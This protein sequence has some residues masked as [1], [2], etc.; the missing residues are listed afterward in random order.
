MMIERMIA[1]GQELLERVQIMTDRFLQGTYD[2]HRCFLPKRCGGLQSLF[3]R[4]LFAGIRLDERQ[5]QVIRDLPPDA[6]VVYAHKYKSYFDFLFYHTRYCQLGLPVPEVGF[7][8]FFLILQPISRFFRIIVAQT[9]YLFRNLSFRSPYLTG[10]IER[11]LQSGHHGFL[12]LVQRGGFYRR[13]VKDKPDPLRYL[14]D[15]QA[16]TPKPVYIVP[17]L[18][19]FTKSP[20]RSIPSLPDVLFG[21]KEN[22]G[23]LRRFF[24]MMQRRSSVFVEISEPLNLRAFL[25]QPGCQG[26]SRGK[27][28]TLLRRRLLDQLNRHRQSVTGPVLKSVEEL[29]E[30]ILTTDRL[31]EYMK[32]HAESKETPLYKIN[33]EAD[34]CI[35]EI[36]ARFNINVIRILAS[37][38][39]LIINLMF[40]G[41]S[42]DSDDIARLKK[43]A[44]KG[45][46]VLVPCHKSHIDYLILSYIL[47]VN[48]MPPPHIAA[49]KNLSF[50][51]MGPIFR[52]C[53]AFFIRRTFKGAVLYS[54][55]FSE[56][57]FKL[58]QEGFNVEFFIEGGRSR[59]GKLLKPKLGL[60]SIII[61]A[62]RQG[63]CED[64]VFVP[65][66]IG[67]DRVPEEGAY[68]HE[69]EGGQK[70]PESL[71]EMIK[72][73]KVLK[74]RYGRIYIRLHEGF[75]VNE[76]LSQR[77]GALADMSTKDQN[78]LVRDIG[79]RLVHCI[80]QVTVITPHAI[81]AAAILNCGREPFT[82]EALRTDI[83]TYMTYLT[84]TR[85]TLTDTLVMDP[86]AAFEYVFEAYQQ[87]RFI[88]PIARDK[89]DPETEALFGINT[90]RRH[91]LE[92]YKNGGIGAFIPAAFTALSILEQDAFQIAS[93]NLSATYGLLREFFEN[94]F[95]DDLERASADFVNQSLNAFVKDAILIPHPTLSDAYNLTS[96]GF[97]KLK[98]FAAFLAP[99]LESYHVVLTFFSR[100]PKNFVEPKDR[101]K[102]IMSMGNRM[103]KKQEIKRPEAVNRVTFQNAVD[104]FLAHGVRGSEE[105]E[106]IHLYGECIRKYLDLLRP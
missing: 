15:V 3:F 39:N 92:Y 13:F 102:K 105:E 22:P 104:F 17:Q 8:Y 51:P 4:W 47:Y 67:Y 41:V 45:P 33:R 94:E 80:D 98:L 24:S 29:K 89:N 12:C 44:R 54:K 64:L 5:A 83:D 56:Y 1:I 75:S 106:K 49:G 74:K 43:L 99:F 52:G 87:R 103:V 82:Y 42:I 55:V 11:E 6:I 31:R 96:L 25:E 91:A 72:A 63:A 85:A 36:T 48:D 14:L 9:L 2:H 26:L 62:F 40:E 58:L 57:V 59:T 32:Q 93:A 38:V 101:L 60:L 30:A 27:Q 100:Y 66:F 79:S 35:D 37:A 95:S 97:R 21:S 61:N 68:L 23:K 88:E 84:L 16:N 53:G 50:W 46:L 73:R 90:G 28:A 77:E 70:K 10:Y 65:V 34:A 19:F 7:D 76:M 78:V 20:L 18:I 71:S 69:L 81:V 86:Q